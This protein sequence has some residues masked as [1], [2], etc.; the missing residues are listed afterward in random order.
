[1]DKITQEMVLTAYDETMTE[2]RSQGKPQKVAHEEGITAASMC[3]ASMTGVEDA[4]ARIRAI[5]L[6]AAIKSLGG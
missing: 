4:K 3:L 1:M 2:A 5:A 6:I